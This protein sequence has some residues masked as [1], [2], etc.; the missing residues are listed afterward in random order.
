MCRILARIFAVLALGAGVG[1]LVWGIMSAALGEPVRTPLVFGVP[2]SNSSEVMGAGA[3]LI[4][5]GVTTLILSLVGGRRKGDRD[6]G[7]GCC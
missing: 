4:A 5:A 7:P 1:C 2:I 6:K 3:G